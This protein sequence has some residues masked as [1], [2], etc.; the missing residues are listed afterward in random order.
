MPAGNSEM[1]P[2]TMT[3]N[4]Y[5]P[6]ADAGIVDPAEIAATRIRSVARVFKIVGW[7][8]IVIYTPI[9][10]SCIHLL[11]MTLSGRRI[12][13]PLV[14]AFA[15]AFNGMVLALA[16]CYLLTGRRV[17]AMDLTVRRQALVLSCFMM[18][19]VPIFTVVGVL[20]YRYLKRHFVSDPMHSR[21]AT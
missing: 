16:I 17:A 8:G 18:I 1:Q 3:D 19:G 9:V 15:T 13:S 4:P 20:C 2:K 12:G 10:L 11:V 14:I 7:M 5:A 21:E 6:P